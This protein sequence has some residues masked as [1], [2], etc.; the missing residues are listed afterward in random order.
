V[1]PLFATA[2]Y[3]QQSSN[4]YFSASSSSCSSSPSLDSSLYFHDAKPAIQLS[5][6][7]RHF[8]PQSQPQCLAIA[9]SLD[10]GS[11][12]AIYGTNVNFSTTN[13]FGDSQTL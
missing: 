2:S 4:E 10:T 6:D 13:T 7:A 8:T 3:D 5:L 1:Q 12:Q 9:S 11:F